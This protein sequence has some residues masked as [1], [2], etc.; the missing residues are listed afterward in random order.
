M[1]AWE[2]WL[3][4]VVIVEIRLANKP[5]P[6]SSAGWWQWDLYD[7]CQLSKSP[8]GAPGSPSGTALFI[9]AKA[10]KKRSHTEATHH[11]NHVLGYSSSWW[12]WRKT[13][14]K[15]DAF[16]QH[17]E[18][19]ELEIDRWESAVWVTVNSVT[20]F[21]LMLLLEELCFN[22]HF[23][24]GYWLQHDIKSELCRAYCWNFSEVN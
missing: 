10:R 20:R 23:T 9:M 16:R 21:A 14:V 24:W 15:R 17:R 19:W 13:E 3:T 2:T 8:F 4:L 6:S 7:I 22:R 1:T 11:Q 5:P 12:R 18:G